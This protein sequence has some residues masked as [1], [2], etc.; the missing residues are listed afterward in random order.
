M[1][2]DEE[3]LLDAPALDLMSESKGS[4]AKYKILCQLRG[5]KM[6]LNEY[7]FILLWTQ[8]T[9]SQPKNFRDGGI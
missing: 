4:Y 1:S 8:L 2:S 6:F 3:V 7:Q 5:C 9:N